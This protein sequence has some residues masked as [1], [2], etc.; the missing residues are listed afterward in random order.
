MFWGIILIVIGSLLLLNKMGVIY[1][2][3]WGYLWPILIIAVGLKLVAG[4]K[5]K[6]EFK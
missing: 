1:G 2:S 3:F 4:D 6:R 5:R